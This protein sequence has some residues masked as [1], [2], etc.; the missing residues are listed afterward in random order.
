MLHKGFSSTHPTPQRTYS[1]HPNY[2]GWPL[3]YAKRSYAVYRPSLAVTTA[4][5][6]DNRPKTACAII[7]QPY[8]TTYGERPERQFGSNT[9]NGKRP[10]IANPIHLAHLRKTKTRA[11]TTTVTAP[12]ILKPYPCAFSSPTCSDYVP[13]LYTQC[14]TANTL[15]KTAHLYPKTHQ[16]QGQL[17]W[18]HPDG[19][20]RVC[21]SYLEMYVFKRSGYFCS[22]MACRHTPQPHPATH[23]HLRALTPSTY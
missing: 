10:K 1:P 17:F 14:Y 23:E 16:K 13:N 2:L 6:S 21:E 9:K 8:L 22:S 19:P 3:F 18:R 15:V 20:V 7:S 4:I 11:R 12:F 5:L